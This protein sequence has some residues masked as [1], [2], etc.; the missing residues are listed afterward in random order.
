MS[1]ENATAGQ[2]ATEEVVCCEETGS[3]HGVAERDVDEDALHDDEDGGTVDC[4]ADGGHDPVNRGTSCPGEEEETNGRTESGWKSWNESRLLCAETVLDQTR[5]G[6]EIQVRDVETDTDHTRDEDAEED[7]TDLTE[8][9]AI[10]DGVDQREDL[11][12]GV[13]DSVDDGSVDLDEEHSRVLDGD[14]ERLDEGFEEDVAELHVALVDFGLGHEAVGSRELAKTTGA[15]EENGVAAGLWEEEEHG[16]E[17]GGR[18]PDGDVDGP[19]PAFNG[20]GEAREK[21]TESS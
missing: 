4:D 10:V 14:F 21:W 20:N 1:K 11:E 13:V 18:G 15:L 12:E 6:V 5:V 9:E 17:D 3:V 16:D 7:D 19:A 8:V 2:S